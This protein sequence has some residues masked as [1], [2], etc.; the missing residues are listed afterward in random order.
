MVEAIM[1]TTLG[2]LIR[3]NRKQANLKLSELATRSKVSKGVIS[4]LENGETKRP[5][6]KTI[7]PIAKSLAIPTVQIIEYYIDID[8]R[9]E[10]LGEL[11][12]KAIELSN[13]TLIAKVALR[14]LQSTQEESYKLVER[15]YDMTSAVEETAVKLTVYELIIKYSREHGIQKYLAKSM[16][17]KYL[18]ERDDFGRL[19][20]TYQSARYLLNYEEFLSSE[21]QI[22]MN[23]KIGVHAYNLRLFEECIKLCNHVLTKDKTTSRMKADATLAICG[24]Y[25]YLGDYNMAESYLDI[26]NTYSYHHVKENVLYLRG[27]I[28]GKR[29]NVAM[30]IAQLKASLGDSSENTAIHIVNELL[31]LYLQNNDFDPIEELLSLEDKIIDIKISTPFKKSEL[32]YFYKLKGDFY[33][34]KGLYNHAIDCYLKSA[35]DYAKISDH[36]QSYKCVNQILSL[37]TNE[38]AEEKIQVLQKIQEMYGILGK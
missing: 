4:K 14:F 30:A 18:I 28:D 2:E 19:Q 3:Q 20:A 22:L 31:E 1:Y 32:A 35:Y 23:Y 34:K 11:F 7:L 6:L 27:A 13:L 36:S 38:I 33:K 26:F 24:S 37:C 8:E 15:L 29:G 5:E 21:E 16:F 10:V 25:Y 17:Q 12:M 9:P